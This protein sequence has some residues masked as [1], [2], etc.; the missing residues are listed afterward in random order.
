MPYIVPVLS[1]IHSSIRSHVNV[2]TGHCLLPPWLRPLAVSSNNSFGKN[3][4]VSY[5][6][7]YYNSLQ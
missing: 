3:I 4:S 1:F 7:L 5:K 6:Y 2:Y